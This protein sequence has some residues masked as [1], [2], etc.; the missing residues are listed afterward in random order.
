MRLSRFARSR[1]RTT[2]YL[3]GWSVFTFAA[4]V[5]THTYGMMVAAGLQFNPFRETVQL[6]PWGDGSSLR[7]PYITFRS[8]AT[9][10]TGSTSNTT[11]T[12]V[13]TNVTGGFHDY[14]LAT[15]ATQSFTSVFVKQTKNRLRVDAV[16]IASTPLTIDPSSV[17]CAVGRL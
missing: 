11:I 13:A 9:S 17:E 4:S 8:Y 3:W 14:G 6:A 7:R 2:P 1:R 16:F 5:P 10:P 15:V 12:A